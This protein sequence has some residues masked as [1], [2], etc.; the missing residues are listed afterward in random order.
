MKKTAGYQMKGFSSYP[1]LN[2]VAIAFTCIVFFSNI[3]ASKAQT[4]EDLPYGYRAIW[5]DCKDPGFDYPNKF[6]ED[7]NL[8]LQYHLYEYF[9]FR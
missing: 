2:W 1:K 8:G 4:S 7:D 5:Y 3:P 6:M 9:N